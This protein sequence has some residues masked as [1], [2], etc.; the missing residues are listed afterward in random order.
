MSQKQT[1]LDFIQNLNGS[2]NYSKKE[3][4]ELFM[5][6]NPSFNEGNVKFYVNHAEKDLNYKFNTDPKLKIIV[7]SISLSKQVD[8][9]FKEFEEVTIDLDNIDKSKFIPLR[10]DTG[11]DM[12][13][14]K[15]NGVMMGTTYM[16]TGES[17]AGKTTVATNIGD[18]IKQVDPTK[19]IGF[20][21]GEMDQLDWTEECLDNP[22][23]CVYKPIFLLDYIDASNYI[24]V[25]KRALREYD[26]CVVDS[27]EVILDQIKEIYGWTGKKA[28]SELIK[29]CREAAAEKNNCLMV[30]QQYTKGGT[31]V[32]SNKI[33]HL[34]T[35]LMFV[36]FDNVGD[37]YITFTKNRRGGHMVGKKL[38]FTKDKIS[39][40]LIF[41]KARLENDLAIKQ[42]AESETSKIKE[43]DGEFD[44]IILGLAQAKEQKRLKELALNGDFSKS[45]QNTNTLISA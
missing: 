9:T 5:K 13:A 28:E 34:F 43:E 45:Q 17:G 24:D 10:S 38:Y 15:R 3:V 29:L 40:R 30:I 37:R 36:M 7:P 39:G 21:S 42:H 11:F 44:S 16:I 1:V 23:L 26:Y 22:R 20:I 25:L 12:I 18:Y 41:D 19:T 35:G 27:F 33:K 6:E 2:S 31:F 8:S 4:V 32:G 14:S